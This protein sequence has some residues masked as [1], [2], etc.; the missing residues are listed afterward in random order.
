MFPK[1]F[2]KSSSS[3]HNILELKKSTDKPEL[4]LYGF[5]HLTSAALIEEEEKNL[6]RVLVV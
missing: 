4:A 1:Q 3:V 2:Q 6:L 5:F